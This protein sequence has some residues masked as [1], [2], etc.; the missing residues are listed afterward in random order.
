M[1]KSPQ[2]LRNSGVFDKLKLLGHEIKDFGDVHVNPTSNRTHDVLEFNRQVIV[3]QPLLLILFAKISSTRFMRV[4]LEN[5]QLSSL[6]GMIQGVQ[7][8]V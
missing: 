1:N 8:V 2:L 6:V 7:Y 4:K 3:I 5:W